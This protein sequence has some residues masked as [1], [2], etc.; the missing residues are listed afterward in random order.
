LLPYSFTLSFNCVNVYMIVIV[1]TCS[2]HTSA[3]HLNSDIDKTR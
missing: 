3:S 1:C 2:L